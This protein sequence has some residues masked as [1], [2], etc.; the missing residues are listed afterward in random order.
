M[1]K[2]N[3]WDLASALHKARIG[4][5]YDADLA[6]VARTGYW[7]DD[8]EPNFNKGSRETAWKRHYSDADK[9]WT[10]MEELGRDA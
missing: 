7:C 3:S 8:L 9:L 5:A 4:C 2:D 10:A 6:S 1:S